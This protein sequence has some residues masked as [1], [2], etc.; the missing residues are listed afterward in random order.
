MN[1]ALQDSTFR[2]LRDFIYEKSGIFIPET[3]KY[4][5][6]HRLSKRI[7]EKNLNGFEDYLYLLRYGDNDSELSRLYDSITTNETFFFREPQ[8]FEVLV[9][10]VIPEITKR[11]GTRGIRLWSA[12]CSTGEEPYTIT[13]LFMERKP[14]IK[15]DV[16]ASDISN[17]VLE[18]AKKGVYG[19]YSV[20]N[21]PEPYIRKYFTLKGHSY[22]LESSVKNSVK[23]MNINFLDEKKMKTM[24]NFDVIFC[25]NV[26]I[27]FDEQAKQKVVSFLYHSLRPGGFLFISLSESLHNITRAFKPVIMNKVVMYQRS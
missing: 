14:G 19:S 20:R 1:P 10:Y 22:E 18:S 24:C 6:E 7:Q 21:V 3:K 9:D 5:L 12:A 4:L 17:G 15:V 23:F 13:M 2:Q 11:N 16:V 26:L 27:Y 25:R 8:Q